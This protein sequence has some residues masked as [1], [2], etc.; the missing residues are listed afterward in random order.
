MKFSPTAP[1]FQSD[2]QLNSP[3]DQAM[4]HRAQDR[5]RF[6][7]FLL[8]PDSG[9]LFRGQEE[10]C[11][12]PL[13]RKLLLA[14][15]EHAPATLTHEDLQREVWDGRYVTP[16]TVKQRVKLLRHT[17]DDDARAPRYVTLD[18]G[19]GY[20]LVPMVT[21][22]APAVGRRQSHWPRRFPVST[23]RLAAL[24]LL[25]TVLVSLRLDAPEVDSLETTSDLA[26]HETSAATAKAA[27][28]Y[29]KAELFYHRRSPGDIERARNLY[30]RAIAADPDY[31]KA[32][33]A[34]A[35]VYKLQYWETAELGYEESLSMQ[36]RAL[37]RALTLDPT[38]A[39]AHA[40]LGSFY[41]GSGVEWELAREHLETALKLA[42]DDAM[43]LAIYAGSLL[44]QGEFE[45]FLAYGRRAVELDPYSLPHRQNLAIIYLMLHRLSEAE[46][47]LEQL[48]MIH[49]SMEES[50]VLDFARLRILQN[51]SD[52]AL[53]LL[54][55]LEHRADQLAL[56]A[57][58]LKG[59]GDDTGSET[60]LAELAGLPG[61]YARLR[62][63]ETEAYLYQLDT[64]E[65]TIDA[66]HEASTA[67][68]EAQRLAKIAILESQ[69]SPFLA[70][71]GSL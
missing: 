5:C 65:K 25:L 59:R 13:S 44:Q 27:S 17:L 32:W 60:I 30:M 42:P 20:R 51:R 3:P 21:R 19:I 23:I 68:T 62:Q 71:A 56:K 38:L 50:L 4:N 7:D 57:M 6:G 49:P 58:A 70:A 43:V 33:A 9:R 46:R 64:T 39:E 63:G 55:R 48:A 61:P 69:F 34:L 8:D 28:H 16:A 36:R 12:A 29:E 54:P 11:L 41:A 37:E 10:I 15:I 24:T 40:R 66:I 14:L 1:Y 35:G 67:D 53:D 26:A 45:Q 2:T 31:A 47:E 18:R 52:G 22:V